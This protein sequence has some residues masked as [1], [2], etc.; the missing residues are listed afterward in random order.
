MFSF[1]PAP[2][3][4]YLRGK[5]GICPR[6]KTSDPPGVFVVERPDILCISARARPACSLAKTGFFPICPSCPSLLAR[7][8]F[9]CLRKSKLLLRHNDHVSPRSNRDFPEISRNR[10]SERVAWLAHGQLYFK[11]NVCKLEVL[12]FH[13]T[14]NFKIVQNILFYLR[15]KVNSSTCQCRA[16]ALE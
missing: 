7:C 16:L 10:H 3:A 6:P 15:N 12:V 11:F 14:N 1:E 5:R 4:D 2:V 9:M 13:L 8:N